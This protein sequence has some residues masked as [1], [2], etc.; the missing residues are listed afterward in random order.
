M[1]RAEAHQL[2]ATLK[3]AYPGSRKFGEDT[4]NLYVT[5]LERFD[6][7]LGAQAVENCIDVCEWP[8]TVAKLVEEYRRLS[9]AQRI[10]DEHDESDLPDLTPEEIKTNMA[11]LAELG[12]AIGNPN[13]ALW[14]T[15]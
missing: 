9:K 12:A 10:E 11:R 5:R 7:E 14:S 3:A 8:P 6:V 1:T 15:I 2:I 4:I 13:H